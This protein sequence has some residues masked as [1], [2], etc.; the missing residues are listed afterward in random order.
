MI[1]GEAV[2]SGAGRTR[3]AALVVISLICSRGRL[4]GDDEPLSPIV[5]WGSATCS[6]WCWRALLGALVISATGKARFA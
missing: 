1:L 5:R 3:A 2:V 6:C 4:G